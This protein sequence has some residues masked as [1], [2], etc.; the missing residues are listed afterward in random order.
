MIMPHTKSRQPA[1]GFTLVELVIVIVIVGIIAT[2]VLRGV[3]QM[4]DT[5]KVEET[6]QELNMLA[7]GIVGNPALQNNGVRSDFGY[8]GDIGSLPPNLDALY[9]NPGSYATWRGPYVDNR[10]TQLPTDYK[11]DPW[12]ALYSYGGSTEITSTGSGSPITRR[13]AN[14]SSHLL[15]NRTGGTVLDLDGTPPGPDYVDSIS[16]SLIQPN[17]AGGYSTRTA[18]VD[19][20]GYFA[21]DSIPIGNHQLQI[22]YQPTG[23]TIRRYVSLTP[24]SEIFSSFHLPQNYWSGTGGVSG[25][26]LEHVA[27]SDS[28]YPDCHGFYFWIT[29][30]SAGGISIASLTATWTGVTAYYRYVIWDGTTVFNS[31]NP[32]NGSGQTATFTTPQTIAPGQTLRVDIDFF[33]TQPTG[34]PDADLDNTTVTI[35]LSDGSSFDVVTEA[36]P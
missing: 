29:N 26:G 20:G 7:N 24:N 9:A 28:L 2:V 36:C 17:G 21:I 22:V 4:A 23:D 34:G 19:P 1:A 5:A 10:F 14:S 31:T 11:T 15:Y 18:T 16:I 13:L 6:K 32:K 35:D 33:K 25:T 27:G 3:G 12:G 8:V 30:S